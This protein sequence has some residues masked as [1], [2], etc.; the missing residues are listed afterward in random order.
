MPAV[1]PDAS[2]PWPGRPGAHQQRTEILHSQ[3]SAPA[4]GRKDGV[5]ASVPQMPKC[6]YLLRVMLRPTVYLLGWPETREK[7]RDRTW[8]CYQKAEQRRSGRE[9]ASHSGGPCT[10]R[11]PRA[12]PALPRLVRTQSRK[13]ATFSRRTRAGLGAVT[14]SALHSRHFMMAV[15][16]ET[17]ANPRAP[18]RG[19]TGGRDA[20]SRQ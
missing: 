12:L 9:R 11:S 18:A 14:Q 19:V 4:A 7:A 20:R 17:Y 10:A 13:R 3:L 5:H 6:R 15:K 2:C 8:V 1:S 16:G